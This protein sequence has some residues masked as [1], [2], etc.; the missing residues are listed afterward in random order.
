MT[1]RTVTGRPDPETAQ[2]VSVQGD[3]SA[4]INSDDLHE[5]WPGDTSPSVVSALREEFP[6]YRI[7]RELFVGQVHFVA[8]RLRPGTHPHTVISADP[9]RVRA[10]LTAGQA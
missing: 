2:T 1:D 5:Y 10:A 7:S 8:C 6:A 4:A 9:A 3:Q